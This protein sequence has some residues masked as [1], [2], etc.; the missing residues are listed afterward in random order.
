MDFMIWAGRT[1]NGVC[2]LPSEMDLI[3]YASHRARRGIRPAGI[4][5]ELTAVGQLF[6][7][8]GLDHPILVRTKANSGLRLH[9]VLRGIAERHSA[10][11]RTRLPLT[12]GLLRKLKPVLGLACPWLRAPDRD[13][14]WA[15]LCLGVYGMFRISELAAPKAK[16]SVL[17]TTRL[18]DIQENRGDDGAILLV[19]LRCSK[20]DFTR[21]GVT[22]KVF[23]NGTETCPVN[24]YRRY[25]QEHCPDARRIPTVA[26][27]PGFRCHRLCKPLTED[28]WGGLCSG[29]W[30]W[31]RN[32]QEAR[33]MGK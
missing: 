21:Q 20:T 6:T 25:R 11:K 17:G 23:E 16:Q 3:F 14:Y 30:V 5:Q 32:P 33:S 10:T 22:I 27:F 26:D 29:S 28:W 8:H 9:R 31:N 19:R 24:A 4:R 7:A 2:P 18:A 12:V 13:M 1:R 15:A